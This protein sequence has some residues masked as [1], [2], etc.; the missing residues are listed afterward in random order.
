MIHVGDV[1]VEHHVRSAVG[2][3][4]DAAVGVDREIDQIRQRCGFDAGGV[5]HAVR[6]RHRRDPLPQVLAVVA[7]GE[8][9]TFVLVE[10]QAASLRD[11][12]PRKEADRD[13]QG[14]RRTDGSDRRVGAL[15]RDVARRFELV[16]GRRVG[17]DPVRVAVGAYEHRVRSSLVDALA[18]DDPRDVD[19]GPDGRLDV[20]GDLPDFLLDPF[21]FVLDRREAE[22]EPLGQFRMRIERRLGSAVDFLAVLPDDLLVVV[23]LGYCPPLER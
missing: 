18:V 6:K 21:G 8:Q 19:I 14:Q 16:A 12:Q 9:G 17:A 7:V 3:I 22:A 2:V 20:A 5:V 1:A 10:R 4:N 23:R 11:E 15:D 13:E